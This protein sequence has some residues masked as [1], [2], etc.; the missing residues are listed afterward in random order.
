MYLTF[1][2]V[3]TSASDTGRGCTGAFLVILFIYL[4]NL[5]FWSQMYLHSVFAVH[6][7]LAFW[8]FCVGGCFSFFTHQ[9]VYHRQHSPLVKPSRNNVCI[10]L[11]LCRVSVVSGMI[12][13]AE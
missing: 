7:Y 12:P 4:T 1:C 13:G 11:C 3:D 6:M 8:V 2:G 10:S 9:G 5:M